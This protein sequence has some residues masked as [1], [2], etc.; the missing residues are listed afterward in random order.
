MYQ[1][2][3]YQSNSISNTPKL[4]LNSSVEML[5]T[6]KNNITIMNTNFDR[7][8]INKNIMINNH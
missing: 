8:N 4:S 2:I 1:N 6:N 3:Q 7:Q 5:K